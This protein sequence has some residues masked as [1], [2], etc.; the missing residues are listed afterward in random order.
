MRARQPGPLWDETNPSLL[1]LSTV[2]QVRPGTLVRLIVGAEDDVAIPDDSRKYAEA[3]GQ[4]GIDARL[5]IE[6]ELGH[7]ILVTPASVRALGSLVHQ[8]APDGG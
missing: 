6:P 2:R 1:P 8:L 7:N 4:R 3:L 5:T